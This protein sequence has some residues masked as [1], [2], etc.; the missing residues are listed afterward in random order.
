[1]ATVTY[2]AAVHSALTT[3]FTPPPTCT[4]SFAND[5][6]RT[7][8]LG[9]Y[10]PLL[11]ATYPQNSACFASGWSSASNGYGKGANSWS[12]G[13][14]CPS[15]QSVAQTFSINT[16]TTAVCCSNGWGDVFTNRNIY[17]STTYSFW[18][19]QSSWSTPATTTVYGT[20][21]SGGLISGATT[22]LTAPG[23]M[24]STAE[25]IFIY[26]KALTS[27]T[28]QSNT[29]AASSTSSSPSTPSP[30]PSH[31]GLS[32]GG[33]A[34]ICV[35][36]LALAAALGIIAVWR[37]RKRVRKEP[38]DVSQG[39]P[40]LSGESKRLA[41]L[42]GGSSYGLSELENRNWH[43]GRGNPAELYSEPVEL[44]VRNREQ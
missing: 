33:I 36:I 18:M 16:R 43:G 39:K 34:G 25:Y 21:L 24:E 8:A 23:G 17:N 12:G 6:L 44:E 2:S 31:N 41:E 5:G 13:P 27:S 37:R 15:G 26:E 7:D 42:P 32:G 22:T 29:S 38:D 35:G 20:V 30:S 19:C 10:R 9:A 40:E 28:S 11:A 14:M 4:D 3:T 1:M